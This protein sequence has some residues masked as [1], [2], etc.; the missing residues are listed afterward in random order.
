MA[1]T[2]VSS[3]GIKDAEVKTADI[4]DA[5]ITTAKVADDAITA[6]KIADDA[7][8]S[9]LIS[10][11]AVDEARLQISNAGSNG[12]YLQKQSGN[13][14]G[15]T[16]AA[17]PAGVGG[18]T[19]VD[20]DDN[21]KVRFGAG[22]D[23][24]LYST[25]TNGWV[26]TPLSGA[27]LYMGTNAGEIYIQT[28]ASGND[29][30][31]K[32][33]SDGAVELY[34]NNVKKFQTY[35]SGAQVNSTNL[36]FTE[37]GT[38]YIDKLSNGSGLV[39]R[40]STSSDADTQVCT[41]HG[42][43]GGVGALDLPDNTRLRAG[44]GN[45]L[46][47]YHDGT[48]SIIDNETGQLR[49]QG[50]LVRLMN[51][52][53]SKV[54]LE[55]NVDGN[56]ELYYD[57]S[58]KFETLSSG[59]KVTGA[60]TVTGNIHAEGHVQLSD[61]DIIKVGTGDDLQIY[62]DGSNSLIANSTGRLIV[63]VN[64]NESAI[65]MHPNGAVELYHDNAKKI[66]T[67]ADGVSITGEIQMTDH[68]SGTTGMVILGADG[69]AKLFHNNS[70]AIIQTNTGELRILMGNDN[71][72]IAKP[73]GAVELY[74]DN[75]KQCETS[76]DGLAFPNGKGINFNATADAS[77]TGVTAGNETF[78]DYEEGTWTPSATAGT[79]TTGTGTYT[80]VGRLVTAYFVI[81]VHSTTS[82][83]NMQ[84]NG[85]PFT[86]AGNAG[87][88]MGSI[89]YNETGNVMR[90]YIT[91]SGVAG[92]FWNDSTAFFSY[93]NCSGDRIRGGVSYFA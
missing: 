24:E 39:F 57:N 70:N 26:Y 58:K 55:A 59:S 56:V 15:L 69:D 29:T 65:D 42:G 81:E 73:D 43:P 21:V 79:F 52:A 18:A 71:G 34:H 41:M 1:L 31:I 16:W 2:Q 72:I 83:N 28:G 90:I 8:T 53:G 25:G 61:D 33:V 78:S 93:A 36:Q 27:D 30:G 80:K 17:V 84:F 86:N 91:G 19:G 48:N 10:D 74:H 12:Q 60:L 82:G 88:N 92:L 51:S 75:T 76:A 85:L 66:E 3:A 20:F 6:A 40:A 32:V 64:G 7:I 4:L 5:N 62:H 45:D 46:A 54:A 37:A 49:I 38:A 9:A 68:T 23:L 47:I 77:G 63:H 11:E 44:T 67:T 14:G 35:A 87:E 89:A 50:D 22:Y 13:T